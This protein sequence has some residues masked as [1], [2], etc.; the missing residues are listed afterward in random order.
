[1]YFKAFLPE[2]GRR[3]LIPA[4]CAALEIRGCVPT[5]FRRAAVVFIGW[6]ATASDRA[7]PPY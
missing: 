4:K 1:M 7:V 6:Y 2:G 5:D 3:Y